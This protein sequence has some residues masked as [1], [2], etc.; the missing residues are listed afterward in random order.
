VGEPERAGKVDV[1][2]GL[3]VNPNAYSTHTMTPG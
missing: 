3:G 1:G 2:L